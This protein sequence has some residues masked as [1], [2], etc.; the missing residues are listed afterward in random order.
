MTSY[1]IAPPSPSECFLSRELLLQHQR[2]FPLAEVFRPALSIGQI[3]RVA[4]LRKARLG[5]MPTHRIGSCFNFFFNINVFFL[6]P[7]LVSSLLNFHKEVAGLLGFR[8]CST[9]GPNSS[10][11]NIYGIPLFLAYNAFVH[12]FSTFSTIYGFIVNWIWVTELWSFSNNFLHITSRVVLLILCLWY[13]I[14]YFSCKINALGDW[15]L[16]FYCQNLS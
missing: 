16:C 10:L 6:V 5:T 8:C 12:C 14:L 7:L 15:I 11:A 3:I 13:W 2:S 4:M 1:I 9:G